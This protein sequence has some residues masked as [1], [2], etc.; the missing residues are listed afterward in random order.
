[1][2]RKAR[3]S[4][5]ESMMLFVVDVSG[6]IGYDIA[7]SRGSWKIPQEVAAGINVTTGE[8][9]IWAWSVFP[10]VAAFFSINVAWGACILSRR[11]SKAALYWLLAAFV[12][13]AAVVIDF[14]HH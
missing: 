10:I 3:F 14:N 2:Q 13:L 6:A 5:A 12:W 11:Q 9:F 1:M 8:P 7:A 4:D